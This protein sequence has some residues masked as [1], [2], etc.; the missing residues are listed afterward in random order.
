MAPSG[1][2]IG[3]YARACGPTAQKHISWP[4]I[5]VQ[6]SQVIVAELVEGD[7]AFPGACGGGVCLLYS[8]AAMKRFYWWGKM[9]IFH[10]IIY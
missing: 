2:A 5:H 6:R 3:P 8:Q 9:A 10:W 7:M 1:Q 4:D